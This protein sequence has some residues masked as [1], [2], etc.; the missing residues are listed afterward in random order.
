MVLHDYVCI[1]FL[2]N[3]GNGHIKFWILMIRE[4]LLN[5]NSLGAWLQYFDELQLF[6]N[7][8]KNQEID[9]FRI[10]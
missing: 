3:L 6:T 10:V 4:C 2:P 7:K 9:E 1:V 8:R 5:V